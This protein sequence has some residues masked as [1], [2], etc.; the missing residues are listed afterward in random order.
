MSPSCCVSSS[1]RKF[2]SFSRTHLN[3]FSDNALLSRWGWVPTTHTDTF[4]I[5]YNWF[6]FRRRKLLCSKLF[7]FRVSLKGILWGLRAP[8]HR[9]LFLLFNW[10]NIHRSWMFN[11]LSFPPV[12]IAFFLGF[13]RSSASARDGSTIN[14]IARLFDFDWTVFSW[15]CEFPNLIRFAVEQAFHGWVYDLLNTCTTGSKL[16]KFDYLGFDFGFATFWMLLRN[17][18]SSLTTD[19]VSLFAR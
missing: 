3:T 17:E 7:L 19:W 13:S 16:W 15:F 18:N 14:I 2:C 9:I 10:L 4:L 1:P 5:R 6:S 12:L 8:P 11:K